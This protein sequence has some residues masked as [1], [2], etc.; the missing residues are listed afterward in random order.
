MNAEWLASILAIMAVGFTELSERSEMKVEHLIDEVL[1]LPKQSK[2]DVLDSLVKD[3]EG[4]EIRDA[5]AKAEKGIAE[6]KVS[7]HEEVEAFFE[8]KWQS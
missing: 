5:V 8:A 3:L 4:Q 1:A 2:H 7:S 6:G